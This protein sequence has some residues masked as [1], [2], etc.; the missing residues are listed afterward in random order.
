MHYQPVTLCAP[1]SSTSQPLSPK[2][3]A[4]M[5]RA[6]A[7]SR[8]EEEGDL[9]YILEEMGERDAEKEEDKDGEKKER[10]HFRPRGS[11]SITTGGFDQVSQTSSLSLDTDQRSKDL[12]TPP[13]KVSKIYMFLCF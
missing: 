6:R 3:E 13:A 4:E 1:P 9:Q 10:I 5:R 11:V 8:I 2:A 7:T 12:L